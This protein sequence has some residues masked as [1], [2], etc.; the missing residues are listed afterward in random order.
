MT[1]SKL[2]AEDIAWLEQRIQAAVGSVSPRPQFVREAKAALLR[3]ATRA[4]GGR[5]GWH[6][7]AWF[8]LWLAALL[9][10]ALAIRR[11]LK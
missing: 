10:L 6:R 4:Q 3:E 2:T 11:T 5:K 7:A 9:L 1:P 8:M